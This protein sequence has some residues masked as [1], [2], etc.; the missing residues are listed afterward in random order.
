MRRSRILPLL[1]PALLLVATAWPGPSVAAD[2]EL[3]WS[4]EFDGSSLDLSRWEPMIGNG[5]PNLCGWGN[6]ELEYYRA[7]NATVSGGMLTIEAREERYGGADY[8]S[9][10]LRTKNLGD[11]T[12][13]RMEMRAR[14]PI[15]QG[16]WPAFWMLPTDEVYGG[17]ASSGEIDIME[18]RGQ[19]PNKVLG[20]IH[21]GGT[22]PDNQSSGHTKVLSSGDF[23]SDF[24]VF[25]LE[26]EPTELRWYVDG[27]LYGT[28]TK[29]SSAGGSFPAPFD[30]PFHLLLNVA[31]GGYFVG[32]PNAST[33]FPQQMV[34]D[35][36]RVYRDRRDCEVVYDSM[37]HAAPFSNGWFYFNGSVGG[38]GIGAET[39]DVAPVDGGSASLGTGWGSG[40]T[41]GFVGGF[42]RGR[43]LELTGF[44]HFEFWI[45]PDA[46]QEYD[47]EINLQD[48]DNGDGK[49]G[50]P[51]DGLDDEFQKIVHV[52]GAGSDVLAGG[53]WQKVSIP[54]TD[55][56]DDNSYHY[57]G[58]G[59]LDAVSVSH[60]GNGMLAN[61][62]VAIISTQGSDVA[63]LTDRWAFVRR[64]AVIAGHVWR[65]DDGDGI[66]DAGEPGIENAT[67][68]LL[69]AA[70]EVIDS[71]TTNAD[72]AYGFPSLIAAGFQ[73]RVDESSLPADLS[74]TFDPD[75]TGTPSSF[76][77]DLGCDEL[78]LDR[79][80]GYRSLATAAP[81]AGRYL[82]RLH[83]ASPNPFNAHTEIRFDLAD[84][85][86]IHLVIFDAQGR[87]VRTLESGVL[88]AGSHRSVWN[89]T[90]DSGRVVAS[91]A[92]F[93]ALR[94]ARGRSVI[95]L[96]LVK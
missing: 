54:L 50:N 89:G 37:D 18:Y 55:F 43:Q 13:G 90:D 95:R 10:R 51:P 22:Y 16:L 85:G 34:V 36:V 8:T 27:Q 92:Y 59:I 32:D 3:V 96:V 77:I 20:T 23:H 66:R 80:F 73:V 11:W 53:G 72:G 17:W 26:W 69:D 35:Y 39:S 21:Y 81:G 84:S 42:G 87:R 33:Q 63:F 88:G 93:A 62:V 57:G 76:A 56:V 75:G 79:D 46:G 70:D 49:I 4:D 60:G 7:Q 64:S 19:E 65:D 61:I 28:Q 2:W 68:E 38:G 83:E 41:P 74:A 29:W 31:V 45:R 5:C 78:S 58:N 24:H 94:T 48:D 91:G 25:A 6:A 71:T 12:Y 86:D 82:D 47:L 40:G 9:A 30:Q 15:G 52:G 67:V 14:L 1:A 44:T